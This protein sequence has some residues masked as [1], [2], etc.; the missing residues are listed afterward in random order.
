MSKTKT[1]ERRT[2]KL[3]ITR[4]KV[5]PSKEENP[6]KLH[7]E[8]AKKV[9]SILKKIESSRTDE[10]KKY[11]ESYSDLTKKL[12]RRKELV[13]IY[14]ERVIEKEDECELIEKKVERLAEIISNAKHLVCYT[15]AGISTSAKIPDYRGSQ[16]IW[17]LLQQG[18]EIGKYDLSLSDPTFTHM[19]LYELHRRKM[20]KHIVSQNCDGLHLRSGLPKISLSEVHG[21]MYIEV[22]KYCKPNVEYWRIFDTTELTAR[23]NHKTNRR[24]RFCLRPLIDTIVHFGERGNLKWPLNWTNA[25]KHSEKADVILCLGSSLKVLKKYHWLWQMD[26]PKNKRAKIC[27][28]NLQWTSKDKLA[29]IKIN[30]KCDQVMELLMQHLNISVPLYC[31]ENDPIFYHSSPLVDEELHTV[32]QPMLKPIRFSENSESS[33]APKKRS[34]NLK[35]PFMK[36]QKNKQLKTNLNSRHLLKEYESSSD[37]ESN[38]NSIENIDVKLE[39]DVVEYKKANG[40]EINISIKH[41]NETLDIKESKPIV[42]DIS[43]QVKDR[44]DNLDVQYSAV[45]YDSNISDVNIKRETDEKFPCDIYLGCMFPNAIDF[46]KAPLL[47]NYNSYTKTEEYNKNENILH[48]EKIVANEENETCLFNLVELCN[49]MKLPNY[50]ES[51]Y[52]YSGLHSIIKPPPPE[53]NFWSSAIIPIFKMNKSAADCDFCFNHYAEFSCQFYK[54]VTV[55]F[56]L[57]KFRNGKKTVCECCDTYDSSEEDNIV[58]KE[59]ITDK[60]LKLNKAKQADVQA[61]WYG[62]GYR[63]N[64]KR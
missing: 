44:K 9:S 24:C 55:E 62:K 39:N 45:K 43:R 36:S 57:N 52:V 33:C 29:S 23:F 48:S 4:N 20:L 18:K 19:A 26:K 21:N 49:K 64:R 2:V 12:S 42:S 34:I 47:V 14:K 6:K 27:I 41:K 40:N 50:Y 61:G 58:L 38:S 28:V 15:G 31:R 11:L 46:V 16:G 51:S 60:R 1:K 56:C 22:C 35:R 25:C 32:S 59:F 17:T 30:G 54:S 8:S 53:I 37:S 10:E 3:Y 7:K 5:N 63:K 13:K